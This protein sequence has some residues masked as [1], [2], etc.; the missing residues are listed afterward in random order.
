MFKN[1]DM[2]SIRNGLGG[3]QKAIGLF[4][5]VV[6][7]GGAAAVT[8]AAATEATRDTYNPRPLFRKFE[9]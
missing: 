9:D 2:D 3:I 8:G 7:K 5:E 4:Q 6:G 1:V